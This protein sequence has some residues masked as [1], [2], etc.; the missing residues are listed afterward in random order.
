[1]LRKCVLSYLE[2]I[3]LGKTSYRLVGP[4]K[5]GTNP[6]ACGTAFLKGDLDIAPLQNEDM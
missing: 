3:I 1:M 2:G 5:G 6:A 4:K